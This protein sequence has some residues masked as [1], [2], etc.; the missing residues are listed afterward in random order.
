V[1]LQGAIMGLSRRE[2]GE[3]LDSIVDFSGIESFIDTPVKRYS[4]GMNAR[5]GFAIAVHLDPDVLVI[6]EV[7]SVG[8][9]AFQRKCVERMQQ[10][11]RDGVAIVF[12]SHNMQAVGDLCDEAVV[13]KGTPRFRG[14][15]GEAVSHYLKLSSA[16]DGAAHGGDGV[17]AANFCVTDAEGTPVDAAAPHTLL[18]LHADVQIERD[19]KELSFGVAVRRATDGASVFDVAYT[20]REM[21]FDRL[22]AGQS[23]HLEFDHRVHLVRGQYIYELGI[24]DTEEARH[25]LYVT[26]G[27][28]RVDEYR[29]WGGYADLE[30][31]MRMTAADPAPALATAR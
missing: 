18:R 17:S 29:S 24:Y 12:V 26:A 16:G 9:M 28:V 5:L 4:S 15:V 3:R 10:F 21:G 13:I 11:K 25:R 8:D 14:P 19:L 22:E 1:F 27:G 23:L 30:S 6:D 7:L 31:E 2:V 20:S